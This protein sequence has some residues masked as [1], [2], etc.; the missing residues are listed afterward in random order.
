ME[1]DGLQNKGFEL[2]ANELMG[3][4]KGYFRRKIGAFVISDQTDVP[5]TE[6]S[7]VFKIYNYFVI[8]LN[9]DRGRFGCAIVTG[10]MGLRLENSQQWYDHADLLIF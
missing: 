8:R 6:F 4:M 9:Y 7:L 1:V 10:G 3:I 5:Y 2:I